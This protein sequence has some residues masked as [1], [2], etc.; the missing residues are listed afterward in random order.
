[1]A[2]SVHIVRPI[3]NHVSTLHKKKTFW[4]VFFKCSVTAC[5]YRWVSDWVNSVISVLVAMSKFNISQRELVAAA[6]KPGETESHIAHISLSDK[7]HALMFA[8]KVVCSGYKC[9]LLMLIIFPV[10]AK[11][12]WES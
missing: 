6:T 11:N 2:H 3:L 5:K 9:T 4:D 10:P 1:M 7:E 12:L 8:T